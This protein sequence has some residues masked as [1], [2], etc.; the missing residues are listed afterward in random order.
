[1]V[2]ELNL[3]ACSVQYNIL[4]IVKSSPYTVCYWLD[5]NSRLAPFHTIGTHCSC[6]FWKT[7]PWELTS[8]IFWRQAGCSFCKHAFSAHPNKAGINLSKQVCRHSCA[9]ESH[10][11]LFRVGKSVV[12]SSWHLN[13]ALKTLVDGCLEFEWG[14]PL[15]LQPLLMRV[16]G[17]ACMPLVESMNSP[18]TMLVTVFTDKLVLRTM[19][20]QG[21]SG[22]ILFLYCN[23]PGYWLSWLVANEARSSAD[24][25]SCFY[26]YNTMPLSCSCYAVKHWPARKHCSTGSLWRTLIGVSLAAR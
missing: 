15:E 9:T 8:S 26:L 20:T 25:A 16:N 21:E 22:T 7:E 3:T 18:F 23:W 6:I 10:A 4:W 14:W 24:H 5:D 17:W 2:N 11:M 1:M 19:R 12:A 13:F